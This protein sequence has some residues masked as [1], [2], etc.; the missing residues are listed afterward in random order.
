MFDDPAQE[1]DELT[2]IIK[3]DIQALNANIAELQRLG[4]AKQGETA[5]KQSSDHSHTVVD[6]LRTRLKDA[7]QEFKDVLTVRTESLKHHKE[8]RQLF[9]DTTDADATIPLLRQRPM[10]PASSSAAATTSNGVSGGQSNP[11][12][13]ITMPSFLAGSAQ[14][15]L[16]ISQPAQDT[17]MSR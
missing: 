10:H 13:S 1:V 12:T 11:H 14:Q 15:Q 2:G 9:S 4:T 3:Q 16:Q 5:S 6:S 7:T 8:R 17:Y